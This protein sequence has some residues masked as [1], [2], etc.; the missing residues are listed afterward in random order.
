MRRCQLHAS[1]LPFDAGDEPSNFADIILLDW[2]L[3]FVVY[4]V[5][6]YRVS[7]SNRPLPVP[8][9]SAHTRDVAADS[10]QDLLLS[11]A[12]SANGVHWAPL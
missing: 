3:L 7:H 2:F 12:V 6:H 11:A 4:G 1:S 5:R 8:S 10:K 9:S